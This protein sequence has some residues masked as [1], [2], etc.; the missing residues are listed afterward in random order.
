MFQQL[1][2]ADPFDSR[3]AAQCCNSLGRH[4][5]G[6]DCRRAGGVH[7]PR[8]KSVVSDSQIRRHGSDVGSG[9]EFDK[10]IGRT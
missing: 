7:I 9:L 4:R 3:I 8:M 6:E 5:P 1:V 2:V 10:K